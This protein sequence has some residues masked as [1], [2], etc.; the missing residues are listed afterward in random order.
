[1]AAPLGGK[2]GAVESCPVCASGNQVE[3][4]SEMIIHFSG[5]RHL[6][7][8]GVPQSPRILI[9]SDC[10]YARLTLPEDARAQLV[11]AL[12]TNGPATARVQP[13]RDAGGFFPSDVLQ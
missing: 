9:C 10:G 12:R 8:P 4:A 3:F 2:C 1:M 6:D 13:A 5:R 11:R 7:H